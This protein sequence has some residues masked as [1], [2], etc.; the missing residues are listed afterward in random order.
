[1]MC[2]KE[3]EDKIIKYEV[4]VKKEKLEMVR[5]DIIENCS[6]RAHKVLSK[7]GHMYLTYL[8]REANVRNVT[9]R[10][11]GVQEN[12]DAPDEELLDIEYDELTFPAYVGII[13]QI[14]KDDFS[15]LQAFFNPPKEELDLSQKKQEIYQ[16]ANSI[17]SSSQVASVEDIN[18]IIDDLKD[19]RSG[20]LAIEDDIELNKNREPVEQYYAQAQA[21]VQLVKVDE[22]EK[23]AYERA[24]QFFKDK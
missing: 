17:L 9:S 6:V 12:F 3:L 15:N 2:Y 20:I 7:V 24:K 21:C 18:S 13:D 23:E 5:M 11:V 1:M 19:L 22:I 8:I 16:E 14:L 10:V 4:Q